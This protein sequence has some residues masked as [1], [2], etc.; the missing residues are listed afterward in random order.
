M[1]FDPCPDKNEKPLDRLDPTG[2]FTAI[3]R[4]IGCIGDSLS[5]GEF[6]ATDPESGNKTYHD[7]FEYSWGQF[8]ARMTGSKVWNFSRGGMTA[9][10][11]WNGFAE[12]HGFW[13]T[14]KLC[15][16]YLIALGV[17]DNS[18]ALGNGIGI[19]SGNDIDPENGDNNPATVLGY[20]GRIITRL[21]QNRPDAFFFPVTVPR[22]HRGSGKP[23]R[24]ALEDRLNEGIRRLPDLFPRTYVLDIA[25]Y[26]PPFDD[27]AFVGS[28]RLGGHLNPMGYLLFARMIGSYIDYIVRHNT[29][30]FK[31][32]GF[33]GTP[34]KNTTDSGAYTP[35]E[36]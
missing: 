25:R 13:G 15:D 9:Q 34:W 27:E 29:A 22:D 11:Y 16:A 5:S 3:F 33:I 24:Q 36:K 17:N 26:A 10:E 12:R 21:R 35:S 28:Y 6:E 23:E 18:K 7:T 32:V 20:Y 8:L 19:G 2:G 4:T 1:I 30:D 14:D 31:Q